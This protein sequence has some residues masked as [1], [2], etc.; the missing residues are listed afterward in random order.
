[1]DKRDK[2]K[3]G[4]YLEKTRYNVRSRLKRR[5]FLH[6]YCP[7]CS[8]YLIEDKNIRLIAMTKEGEEAIL[9][10]FLYLNIYEAENKHIMVKYPK[11]GIEDVKCPHC[12][13]SML[14]PEVLCEICGSPTAEL[15]VAAVH[16]KVPFL[17]CLRQGCPW[18]GITPEDELLLIQDSS[19][20]W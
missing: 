2:L 4:T 16:F 10:L 15:L 3:D 1:M 5:R 18:H 7:R 12:L 14:H 20:E 13:Q 17:I 11:A 8:A 6:A 9:E 19:R